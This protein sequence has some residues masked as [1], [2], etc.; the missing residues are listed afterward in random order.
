M[1]S[2]EFRGN[3]QR[4]RTDSKPWWPDKTP[5]GTGKPNIVVIYMDDMGYSDIGCYGSEI[6]TPHIDRLAAQ[7][8]RFN[9]YTTH[10]VCSAARAALFTG[11]N[12]HSVGTGW[13]ANNHAGFPGYTGVIPAQAQT[14]AESLRAAGYFTLA[15]GKWHN[16][17][18]GI[19]PD[20]TW[21]CQRGFERFY[22]FLEGETSYFYP[23][24]LVVD[25][26]VVRMDA[27]PEGYYAT[28]DWTNRAIALVTDTRN[29]DSAR[30]FYLHLAYNAVHGPLQAKP[31]DMRKYL[32]VY[33]AGWDALR[34]ARFARQ[35]AIGL[36]PPD[37]GLAPRDA[38]VPAWDTVTLKERAHYSRHMATYAAVLDCVDQN[39]G[40]L[41]A[42]LERMGE[43]DNTIIVFSSDNGGTGGAGPTGATNYARNYAGLAPLPLADD[44]TASELLGTARLAPLYPS[45]WGQVSNTPFANYKTYTGGGGRRVGLIVSW[46]KVLTDKGAVRSQA[47]HVIDIMPT[48]LELAGVQALTEQ[49]GKPTLQIHGSS[50]LN[51]LTRHDAKFSRTEQYYECWANRAFY[52]DGWVA[53][54]LQ[55]R[56][57][58][59]D[60]DNW[61]LHRHADDFSEIVDRATTHPEILAELVVAFD[62]AAQ[63]NLVYP[64]D[65]RSTAQKFNNTPPGDRLHA[66]H[67]RRFFPGGQT[68]HRKRV[69]PLIQDRSFHIRVHLDYVG[70]DEG[71]LFA[72]GD[73]QG[74]LC[75]VVEHG[76]ARLIYNG[77][78]TRS[79]AE[80]QLEQ[81]GPCVL[82]FEYCAIGAR[83]GRGRITFNETGHGDWVSMSPTLM[84]G[85]HEG[86]DIGLDR[87]GPV[88]WELFDRKGSFPYTNTIRC[89]EIEAGATAPSA[90]S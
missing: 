71:I 58:K 43:M 37:A 60:F 68:V 23:A 82:G 39:V 50:F 73:A 18:S 59:I 51:V 4:D 83:Q 28:D 10:P 24:R 88:D 52:R 78:G 74:G 42:A 64:L 80:L 47:I 6:A 21:P 44:M 84:A 48:L 45:G 12:G 89:L 62:A 53:I 31:E 9:H 46:P 35:K 22:G 67:V 55:R 2:D 61:T 65:N 5:S 20:G 63:A 69:G 81:S 15:V 72:V 36:I 49:G 79:K 70:G 32:G 25:N 40:R 87:R 30:P 57:E 56:G 7:G 75:M 41:V 11:R 3:I 34:S 27:L 16:T 8:L 38:K 76:V 17:P 29:E 77:F 33:D 26:S 86:L 14:L 1:Q 90:G 66:G 85:F 13:L 19:S 54:S